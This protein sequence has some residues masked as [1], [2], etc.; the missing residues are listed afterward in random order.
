MVVGGYA[1]AA[2]GVPRA[3]GDIDLWVRPTS[4]NAARVILA[5]RAFGAP[6]AGIAASDFTTPD[7][8]YQFGRPPHRVDVLTT[9]D[10]L[11][12]DAAWPRRAILEL[13][14][15]VVSVPDRA[16][17]IANKLASGRP[18]DLADVLR[19]RRLASD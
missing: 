1:V 5:L 18:Q 12:F 17:L 8:V 10:G 15:V 4:E 19:L 3:T 14:G 9:I 7:V 11:E 6:L 13:E 16:D 2:H